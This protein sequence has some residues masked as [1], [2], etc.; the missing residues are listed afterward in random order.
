[1]DQPADLRSM[2]PRPRGALKVVLVLIG[3]FA[4]VG[5]ICANWIPSAYSVMVAYLGF[6][7]HNVLKSP[8]AIIGF[9][10]SWLLT[11]PSSIFHALFA[12]VGLYFLA[13]DLERRWGGGRLIRFLLCA[14]CIGNALVMLAHLIPGMP[15]GLKPDFVYGPNAAVEA[16]AFAWSAENPGA[17]LRLFFFLPMT[18]KNFKW[19][20]VGFVVLGL[21]LA[22]T[23]PVP[24]G[25]LAPVGGVLVGLA[26]SGTP[27]PLRRMWLRIRL[28]ILRKQGGTLDV[29]P[30][31]I[32][33][34]RPKAVAR[35]GGP[36]LRVVPGGLDDL[37][38]RKPSKDK[39][40]LN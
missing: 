8:F 19:V 20:T 5:A 28:G 30:L 13:P 29:G 17:V 38:K 6:V 23:Q 3:A 35:K 21:I 26:M 4:L 37:E 25:A 14:V 9:F 10:T 32:D 22:N 1:M 2:L 16:A 36:P 40:Y 34:P 24:E 12:I 11:S 18:G 33:R 7:P 27:S 15:Q 39:R 31:D